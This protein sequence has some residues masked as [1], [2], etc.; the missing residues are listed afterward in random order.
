MSDCDQQPSGGEQR[1]RAEDELRRALA[2]DE[3][4]VHY[5][6]IVSLATARAVGVEALVRWQHPERGLLAPGEFIA[7]AE[8]T[9][10]IV[11]LGERVLRE[12][13]HQAVAWQRQ[14]PDG[15]PLGVSVNLSWCQVASAGLAP[16][17]ARALGDSAV[18]PRQVSL[19]I[20]E[21]TPKDNAESSIETLNQLK[22]L[23]VM[24]VL[25]NFGTGH[26][27]LA[28]LRSFPLGALRI[29]RCFVAGIGH[30]DDEAMIR[31]TADIAH[32]LGLGV[33]AEGVETAEQAAWLGRNG[34]EL[35]Q[36]FYYARPRPGQ[37]IAPLI[38]RT[39]PSTAAA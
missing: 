26:S 32:A 6:P 25:D 33:I 34:C 37:K 2:G 5:Q 4:C 19:E 29:D 16:T 13:C 23:G 39:L 8:Q 28:C 15:E 22:G 27:T 30:P 24:L 21:S 20:T 35:A 1:L 9:G 36:G 10:L 12:A 38:G 18:D 17:V 7:I 11:P 3:L 31:Q 14:R